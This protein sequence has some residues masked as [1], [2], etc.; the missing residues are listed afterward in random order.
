MKRTLSLLLAVL[1]LLSVPV[2][3]SA[4]IKYEKV[5]KIPNVGIQFSNKLAG[6]EVEVQE[7]ACSSIYS[8]EYITWA[9]KHNLIPKEIQARYLEPITR[10]ELSTLMVSLYELIKGK[11]ISERKKF[12]DTHDVDFEKVAGLGIITGI[13]GG[14]FRP[15]D[16]LTQEQVIVAYYRFMEKVGYRFKPLDKL[17]Y[18]YKEFYEYSIEEAKNV[19]VSSWARTAFA[20]VRMTS[21]GVTETIFEPKG[22]YPVENV[23]M[24]L[25]RI[26]N[27]VDALLL[28][29]HNSI[30]EVKVKEQL[31][32][33]EKMYPTGTPWGLEKEY[34]YTYNAFA[35][36]IVRNVH[37]CDA[38]ATMVSESIFGGLH[39]RV[40]NK[41][42]DG[43]RV[44]DRVYFNDHVV[45]V[46][47]KTDDKLVIA[48]GNY[49]GKVRWGGVITREKFEQT[50]GYTS[51][52]PLI[53]K[54][55]D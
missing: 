47:D 17:D 10:S 37:A 6:I 4:S 44:G 28:E 3:A 11:E 36:P 18:E 43:V 52:Y 22:G 26:F 14:I 48:E 9:L 21:I 34:T 16:V 33:I 1:M 50:C 45:I 29:G 23:I 5:E 39:E 53:V 42:F 24:H 2:T 49:N 54:K 13:G 19:G 20:R 8:M 46:I 55:A 38:F 32:K 40:I 25:I 12:I 7:D 51:N 30:D 41:N 31:K 35:S 27:E 15:N